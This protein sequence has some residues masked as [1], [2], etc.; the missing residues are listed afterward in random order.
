MLSISIMIKEK[1]IKKLIDSQLQGT[2][3]FLVDIIVKRGNSI[4]VFIDGDEG[5]KLQDCID[6]SRHIESN[7]DRDYE[8][9]SLNVSS[10]G[11]DQPLTLLRQYKKNEGRGLSVL[12]S[13]GSKI[14]GKLI[15]AKEDGI[16]ILPDPEKKK[17]KT[18][19]ELKEE[20]ISFSQVKESKLIITIKNK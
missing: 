4:L 9:F 6:L 17:K 12:L 16:S 15:M 5:V 11:L 2:D 20:F 7:L 18:D 8:D 14:K 13:D 3:I 1:Q 10:H 19:K